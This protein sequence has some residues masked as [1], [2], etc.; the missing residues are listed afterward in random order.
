[1]VV[2]I[3][4]NGQWL[5][6][7]R[8]SHGLWGGLWCLPIIEDKKILLEWR[9]QFD[10]TPISSQMQISHS[11]THFTWLLNIQMFHVEPEQQEHLTTELN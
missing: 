10:L 6:Q 9:S 11:F 4:S 2:L 1:D 5:W 3:Q 8:D 7:Q